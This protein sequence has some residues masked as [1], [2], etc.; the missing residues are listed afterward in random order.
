VTI[1]TTNWRAGFAAL[2]ATGVL[3]LGACSDGDDDAADDETSD[4]AQDQSAPDDSTAT[5]EPVLNPDAPAA[6]SDFCKGAIDAI[7]MEVDPEDTADDASLSAAEDLEAPEEIRDEWNK[8]LETSRSMATI[9][10]TDPAA[11]EQASAAYEEI[12]GAE[13]DA[14]V[15]LRRTSPT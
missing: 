2:L 7:S 9:D 8:V 10:Y 6:D 12:A 13:V 15:R 11:A 4:E 5:D 1:T 3:L 14:A